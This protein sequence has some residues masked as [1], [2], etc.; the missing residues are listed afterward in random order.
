VFFRGL[1]TLLIV[2]YNRKTAIR[3]LKYEFDASEI[4][5]GYSFYKAFI[6]VINTNTWIG[7]NNKEQKTNTPSPII[8]N[9]L[10]L[11]PDINVKN[12]FFFNTMFMIPNK[13]R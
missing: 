3:V 6:K 11:I 10:L 1:P 8:Y 9:E 7:K 13:C 12:M 2:V 5:G 4:D